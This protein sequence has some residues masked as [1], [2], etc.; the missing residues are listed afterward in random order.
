[1]IAAKAH[2]KINLGLAVGP[3]RAD[4]RHAVLTVLQRID[5]HDEV[6]L[7]PAPE[8]TVEGFADTIVTSALAAL[9]RVSGISSGWRVRIEKRIP[10][11]AGL[12]GGSSDA[13]A[14]LVLANASLDEPLPPADLRSVAA[15]IGADVPFFLHE[16]AQIA[17]GDGTSLVRVDLP[18]DYSALLVL[19]DDVTKTS[20]G[21]VYDAF[22]RRQGA[23]GFEAR[24][25]QF[26]RVLEEVEHAPDLAA[27]PANDLASSPLA[28]A[29]R[30]L[31]AFR[32]DVSG[33]G[34]TVYG[35]FTDDASAGRAEQAMRSRGRTVL[36]HPV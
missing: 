6:R 23:R 36:A 18:R 19:P 31:G 20:T 29:L 32:A 4:G 11:A 13:A 24:A 12:A 26:S 5:L 15:T 9:T 16:G 3:R 1:M 35:L 10:V 17:S 30:D 22:D 7:E 21:D 34:P 8:T 25:A 33:A 14:A 28:E 27:L 2:A